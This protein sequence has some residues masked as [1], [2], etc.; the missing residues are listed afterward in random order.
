MFEYPHPLKD[1]TTEE[2]ESERNSNVPI[3]KINLLEQDEE[4]KVHDQN[5][6]VS[7]LNE[8]SD[9]GEA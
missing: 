3:R 9:Y 5:E 8:D 4:R 2:K 6:D 7:L 1:A